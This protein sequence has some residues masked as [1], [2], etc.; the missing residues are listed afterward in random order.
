MHSAKQILAAKI[1]PLTPPLQITLHLSNIYV[2]KRP[3]TWLLHK[4]PNGL[5]FCT[6]FQTDLTF[7]HLSFGA[8]NVNESQIKHL[9]E[10]KLL[11]R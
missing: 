7:T 5:L 10:L 9:V 6:I 11:G 1:P 3:N 4:R 2:P 8:R